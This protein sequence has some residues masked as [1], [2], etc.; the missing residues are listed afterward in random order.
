[1]PISTAG[2]SNKYDTVSFKAPVHEPRS[3]CRAPIAWPGKGWHTEAGAR[4]LK[5]PPL[6]A[7]GPRCDL[8]SAPGFT[9]M[10]LIVVILLLTIMLGFAIPA[11]EGSV[12]TGSREQVIRELMSDVQKLKTAA[13]RRQTVHTLHL[14]LD[15]DRLWVSQDNGV[16]SEAQPHD[17]SV[18]RLPGDTRIAQVRFPDD[19]QIRAGTVEI[20]FYPQGYS[21]RAIIQLVG[22]GKQPTDL[23]IEA[24]LPIALMPTGDDPPSF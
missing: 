4:A 23:V 5:L 18:W 2:K 13:L 21:D 6:D 8:R 12:M 15:R 10:E 20:K 1:M 16:E 3:N 19:R 11:F 7:N 24:F 9:L 22:E 17:A 14:D